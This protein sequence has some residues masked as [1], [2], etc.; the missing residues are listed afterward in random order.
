[1]NITEFFDWIKS[2][3]MSNVEYRRLCM[4]QDLW[5]ESKNAEQ[6]EEWK[7]REFFRKQNPIT[8]FDDDVPF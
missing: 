4:E 3:F 6:L 8:N 1:M 5:V 2:F 7:S